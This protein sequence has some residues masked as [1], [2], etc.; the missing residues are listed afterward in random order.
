MPEGLTRQIEDVRGSGIYPGTG[1]YP[2]G[3]VPVR[4]PAQLGHPE[5][6][7]AT[8]R[9]GELLEKTALLAGRAI[10][11]GYFV[12]NGLNHF[13]NRQMMTDYAKSKGVPAAA[14]AVTASGAMIV[15]GGL[16]VITGASPKIGAGLISAFLLSASPRMHAF[17]KETDPQTQMAEMANF[18]KNM[19]LVGACLMA[20]GH[21]EPWPIAIDA[22]RTRAT[23]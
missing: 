7:R 6:T 21:P 18:T 14:L 10:F 9:P 16:S 5:A 22:R 12:Y 20:A 8:R 2:E 1:P 15:A 3:N 11:G 19:A 17:W 23:A 13:R 4:T